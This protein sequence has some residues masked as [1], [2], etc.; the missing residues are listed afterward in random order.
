[1]A[2]ELEVEVWKYLQEFPSEPVKIFVFVMDFCVTRS[3]RTAAD[4]ARDRERAL[5][6]VAIHFFDL[7]RELA[8]EQARE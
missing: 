1:M 4:A 7:D 5:A 2:A 8:V 6:F 3:P